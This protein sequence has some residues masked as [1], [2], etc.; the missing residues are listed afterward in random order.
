MQACI[1]THVA[2]ET[3]GAIESCL[4]KAGW[5]L[6]FIQAA[7]TDWTQIDPCSDDLWVVMGG[8]IGVYEIEAYPFLKHEIAAIQRRILANR[9]VLGVCLGAQLLANA[10]G[11]AVVP[12]NSGKEL[13]WYPLRPGRDH[14]KFPWLQ[15]LFQNSLALLHWHGDTIVLP[16]QAMHLAATSRYG[17]QAFSLGSRFLGFQFH[18]EPS[19]ADLEAWYVGHALEISLEG[20]QIPQLRQQAELYTHKA[21]T[22]LCRILVDWMQQ[23]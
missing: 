17:V 23:W 14:G 10:A 12:G 13:G 6:R 22:A 3:A 8:P 7:Q 15:P 5:T 11:G 18:A 9:P 16:P 2:F 20:I 1:I 4:S 19:V 21:R